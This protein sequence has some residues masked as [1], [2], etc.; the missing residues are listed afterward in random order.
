MVCQGASIE[1]IFI[2]HTI[3]FVFFL[4]QTGR[5]R[6]VLRRA[7]APQNNNFNHNNQAPNQQ[8]N[9]QPNR[10]QQEDNGDATTQ[11]RQTENIPPARPTTSLDVWRRGAYTFAASLWPTYGVDPRI[12]Q[13]FE[14]NNE[15]AEA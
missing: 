5:L 4:Y 12:A 2:F 15:Q 9:N 14:N 10:N 11:N 7:V 3:A 8:G 13:A 1:R 6:L